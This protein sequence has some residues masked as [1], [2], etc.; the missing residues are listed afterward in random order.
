[1]GLYAGSNYVAIR[2]DNYAKARLHL[3]ELLIHLDKFLPP[4]SKKENILNELVDTGDDI[5]QEF[6]RG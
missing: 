4:G 1:M 2:V 6:I 5:V 3:L